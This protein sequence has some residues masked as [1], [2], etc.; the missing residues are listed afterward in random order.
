MRS[1]VPGLE[2]LQPACDLRLLDGKAIDREGLVGF[3]AQ[4]LAEAVQPVFEVCVASAA[5]GAALEVRVR[6]AGS[7]QASHLRVVQMSAS[8]TVKN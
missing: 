3:G 6:L 1:R 2:R 5:V 4:F 8:K 7:P